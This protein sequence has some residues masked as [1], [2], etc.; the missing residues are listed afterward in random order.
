MYFYELLLV[1]MDKVKV[2]KHQIFHKFKSKNLMLSSEFSKVTR[3]MSIIEA[4]F[5]YFNGHCDIRA[6]VVDRPA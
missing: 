1:N 5:N 6:R 4:N 2:P 3:R